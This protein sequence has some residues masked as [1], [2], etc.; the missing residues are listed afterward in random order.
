MK[1]I[2]CVLIALTSLCPSNYAKCNVP[3]II[4]NA[5]NQKFPDSID[6]KWDRENSQEY[7]VEFQ[8]KGQKYSANFSLNGEWQETESPITF[9]QL[10]E[11]VK[12]RFYTDYKGEKVKSVSQID[13]RNRETTFEVEIINLIRTK[14]IFYSL[15]GIEFKK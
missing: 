1:N 12:T 6:A 8:W 14:E 3:E 4:L 13:T 15:P 5:F 2:I 7:E 11:Y 9:A 10:P